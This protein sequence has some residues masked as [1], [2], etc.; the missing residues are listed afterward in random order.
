M[1]SHRY[2]KAH[3][4]AWAELGPNRH[5]TPVANS[6]IRKLELTKHEVVDFDPEGSRVWTRYAFRPASLRKS[7]WTHGPNSARRYRKPSNRRI[8]TFGQDLSH[9]VALNREAIPMNTEELEK[10]GTNFSLEALMD[11]RK[12]TRAAMAQIAHAIEPGMLEEDARVMA[13]ET[14]ARLGSRKG[15]HKILVRFGSNTTKNFPE[16]SEPATRLG[17]GDVFFLDIGPVWGDTEGDA[18]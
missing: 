10:T 4:A 7:G 3:S 14:L 9:V 17:E 8:S 6:A 12:N 18:G 1:K 15:W 2:I 16:P 5:E 13:R 11:A